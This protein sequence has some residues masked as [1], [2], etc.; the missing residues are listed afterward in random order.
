MQDRSEGVA[1]GSRTRGTRVELEYLAED[2]ARCQEIPH[3]RAGRKPGLDVGR[4]VIKQQDG[5][6]TGSRRW[7]P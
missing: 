7:G 5:E 2:W 4:E 3:K 1:G 6:E